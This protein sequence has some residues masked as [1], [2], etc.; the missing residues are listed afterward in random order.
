MIP[1]RHTQTEPLA[2]P[3]SPPAIAS[4]HSMPAGWGTPRARVLR[5]TGAT[6][7]VTPTDSKRFTLGE[8]RYHTRGEHLAVIDA[9]ELVI[10]VDHEARGY[11]ALR[12]MAASRLAGIPVF[13]DALVCSPLAIERRP[14][15][16]RPV[17]PSSALSLVGALESEVRAMRQERAQRCPKCGGPMIG[18]AR[19]FCAWIL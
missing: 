10:V 15:K 5:V 7:K 12:N 1:R 13:G 9:G 17:L 16:A 6:A 18:H 8:L 3:H 14:T 2:S 4:G 11:S 19:T